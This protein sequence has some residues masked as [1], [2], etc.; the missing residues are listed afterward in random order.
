MGVDTTC[1]VCGTAYQRFPS[2]VAAGVRL[3]CSRTCA[4]RRFR[5][6]HDE[7]VC[8]KCDKLFR[9][10][11]TLTEHGFS[12]YCSRA[13]E[14][15]SRPNQPVE[16]TC[17]QC[18]NQFLKPHYDVHNSGHNGGTFCSRRCA[19]AFKRKLRKRGEQE[20]FTNWQK[21]EWI[22][23]KCAKCGSEELLELD[24]ILPRFAGG[25]ATREN[26]QTLCRTCNRV[27]FWT[28]DYPLYGE[29]L[30]QRVLVGS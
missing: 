24:H 11:K 16:R 5:D 15:A 6:K 30:K 1:P 22:D 18:G 27:K 7:V 8:Q 28:D 12:K 3:T 13:C 21:R 23:I 20:M 29:L 25:A 10:R 14:A 17:V 19:D 4:A 9:G 26:A 2:Q